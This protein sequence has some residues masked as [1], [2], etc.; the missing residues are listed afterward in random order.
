M[1]IFSTIL[2]V[3]VLSAGIFGGL[4]GKKMYDTYQKMQI[5]V[6]DVQN[7]LD[8]LGQ[9][10]RTLKIENSELVQKLADMQQKNEALQKRTTTYVK[11]IK[12]LY[13]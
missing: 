5:E 9:E 4:K 7:K 13:E 11:G 2:M 12:S 10:Y 6:L 8:I 3:I 1:N